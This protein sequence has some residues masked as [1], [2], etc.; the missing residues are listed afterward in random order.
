MFQPWR[1]KLR[2]AEEALR[3][4]RL[5]DADQ[6]LRRECLQQYLP[7][8]RLSKRLAQSMVERARQRV[9]RGDSSAGWQDL[10]SAHSL[11]GE[12]KELM[13][14]RESL[15]ERALKDAE[16]YLAADDPAAALRRISRLQR[17]NVS[18]G[19]VRM[20]KEVAMQLESAQRL[21][22]RGRFSDAQRAL[23]HTDSLNS[24]LPI[25]QQHKETYK[26]YRKHYQRQLESLHRNMAAGNWSKVSALAE[27]LLALSP[28]NRVALDA[29]QRAWSEVGTELIVSQNRRYQP[30]NQIADR[31]TNH[32]STKSRIRSVEGDKVIQRK[33]SPRFFLWV[34][35]VGGYLVCLGDEIVLGQAIP[36]T[37]NEVPILA[38]LS[39]RHA[40]I[41]RER[42]EYLIEPC[43]SVSVNGRE[44]QSRALLIDGVEIE[45]AGSV[46]IRFRQPHVLSAS[47]RL[48]FV[49]GHRTQPTAD[50]IV[51]MAESCVLGPRKGNHIVCRDWSDDVVLYRQDEELFCRAAEPIEIDD[52][53]HD[54]RGRVTQKSRVVG[55]DFALSLETIDGD[56]AR[57]VAPD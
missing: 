10:E 7:G 34:D 49:S 19:R 31:G 51:L 35:A 54:G 21:A 28:E 17:R 42:G 48:D 29:R 53:V 27:Q 23:S 37:N 36:G 12:T 44:I 40:K 22:R 25:I 1:L 20:L 43:K 2:E 9:D 24:G 38:D 14:A 47:A 3:G 15:V 5:E 56:E 11:A 6:L 8:R 16:E 52:V 18:G 55:S 39:R 41:R 45:L 13:A 32:Q 57:S 4:G 26:A 33:A 50:A 30:T 46:K